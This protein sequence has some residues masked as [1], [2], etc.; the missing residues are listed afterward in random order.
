M[1]NLSLTRD[2]I[3][4]IFRLLNNQRSVSRHTLQ[5]MGPKSITSV[6]RTYDT[7]RTDGRNYE[8]VKNIKSYKINLQDQ[9]ANS[10]LQQHYSDS[11]SFPNV[12]SNSTL[13]NIEN[14]NNKNYV[15]KIGKKDLISQSM[16]SRNAMPFYKSSKNRYKM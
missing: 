4:T 6:N 14:I 10:A 7:H 8:E 3:K 16:I 12:T 5:L 9:N 11:V 1:I 2:K 13:P 15:D